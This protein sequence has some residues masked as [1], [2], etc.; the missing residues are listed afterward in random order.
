MRSLFGFSECASSGVI[1]DEGGSSNFA[2]VSTYE[3]ERTRLLRS[4]DEP[5]AVLARISGSFVRASTPV[6][7][8]RDRRDCAEVAWLLG[9]DLSA[10]AEIRRES[11][12]PGVEEKRSGARRL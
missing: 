4:N 9:D 11:G 3:G 1:S 7:L 8:D 5:D 6:A 12:E 10:R 2:M